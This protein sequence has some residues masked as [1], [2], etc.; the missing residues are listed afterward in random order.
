MLLATISQVITRAQ[1]EYESRSSRRKPEE[2]TEAPAPTVAAAG[3]TPAAP[4]AAQ[5]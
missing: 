4:E 2:Q 1:A 3:P 5:I